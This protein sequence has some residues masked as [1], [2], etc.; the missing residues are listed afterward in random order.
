MESRRL[1]AAG[2]QVSLVGLGCN[3]FGMKLDEAASRA[4]V[5]AALEAGVTHFDTAEIYGG[6]HSEEYLGRALGSRRAE[7]VVA[8]KF[9]ARPAE[10]PYRP[11]VLRRRIL[12]GCEISLQRLG[13][14]YIDLYYQHRPDPEAP[15]EEAL[16]TLGELVDAGKVRYAGC[17]NY[18]AVQ[19]DE[20]AAAAQAPG[21]ARF[22]AC[23]IHWNLLSRDVESEVVPAARR[24]EMGVVPYFPLEAGL[25]TGKYSDEGPFPRGLPAGH[26]GALRQARHRGELR[27]HPRAEC[28]RRRE[29]PHSARAGFRLAGGTGR[30]E[31]P[32]SR[33]PPLPSRSSGTCGPGRRGDWGRTNCRRFPGDR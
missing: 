33:G 24:A 16:E 15:V 14:D 10:E 27:L 29:G 32:S 6:G 18:S 13:T 9:A 1:G 7:V 2:P 20:A 30:R 3:N 19:L 21:A 8:T 12:E 4:V 17:S 26:H 5:S 22:V 31:P 25:L 11:G 28:F 23:Q